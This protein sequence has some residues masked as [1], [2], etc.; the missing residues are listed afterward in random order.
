MDVTSGTKEGTFQIRS[1]REERGFHKVDFNLPSCSCLDFKKSKLPCKHFGAV[2][3]LVDGWTFPRLPAAYRDGPYLTSLC[4]IST[5]LSEMYSE[6][7]SPKDDEQQVA[8]ADA[9]GGDAAK[10]CASELPRASQQTTHHLKSQIRAKSSQVLSSLYYVHDQTALQRILSLLGEAENIAKE[11]VATSSGIA[12]RGSP[13]KGCSGFKRKKR[14]EVS[15]D[16]MEVMDLPMKKKSLPL[17]EHWL[18]RGRVGQ[19]AEMLR[20][21]YKAPGLIHTV[22]S[23]PREK[24]LFESYSPRKPELGIFFHSF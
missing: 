12:I 3:L 4:A 10:G 6:A 7:E 13:T 17:K 2:F 23:E 22:V 5:T 16:G 18:S 15:V 1:E 11:N 8:S 9:D 24:K 20:G 21:A 14:T 19:K